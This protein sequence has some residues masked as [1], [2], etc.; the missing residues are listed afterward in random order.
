MKLK[1]LVA[2]L[3]M[4]AGSADFQSAVDCVP[5]GVQ[6]GELRNRFLT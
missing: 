6:R 4:L 1:S 3:L 2:A 5:L